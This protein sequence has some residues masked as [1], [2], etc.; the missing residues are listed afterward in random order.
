[1]YTQIEPGFHVLNKVGADNLSVDWGA[2][3]SGDAVGTAFLRLVNLTLDNL[4]IAIGPPFAIPP[5]GNDVLFVDH[6]GLNNDTDLL[7]GPN[8]L[9][10]DMLQVASPSN[11]F[12]AAH[13]FTVNFS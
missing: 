10:V 5:G 13:T 8:T 11:I 3:N 7:P 12:V 4:I 1:M 9:R 2:R 6:V